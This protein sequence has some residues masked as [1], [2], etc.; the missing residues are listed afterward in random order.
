MNEFL[1]LYDGRG[2]DPVRRWIDLVH[3]Q[4]FVFG[5]H[6]N[7]NFTLRNA[8]LDWELGGKGITRFAEAESLA[9]DE[10]L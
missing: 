5:K 1:D 7:I 10:A 8:G 3:D 9:D 6:A 4:A 2:A